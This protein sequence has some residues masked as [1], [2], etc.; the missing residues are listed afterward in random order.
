MNKYSFNTLPQKV[1][2]IKTPN[3]I[4]NSKI[5]YPGTN[6]LIQKLEK[7]LKIYKIKKI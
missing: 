2:P 1:T 6:R 5:P 7:D 3:R 4:I